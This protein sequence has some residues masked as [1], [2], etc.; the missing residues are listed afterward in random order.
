MPTKTPV[1]I[2][3]NRDILS[4]WVKHE[5]RHNNISNQVFAQRLS[6]N[7]NQVSYS[8]ISKWRNN[9]VA[10]IEEGSLRAIASYRGISEEDCELWLTGVNTELNQ[11]FIRKQTAKSKRP[12][13]T[14]LQ[15]AAQALGDSN[16]ADAAWI[17]SQG[18]LHRKDFG[19]IFRRMLGITVLASSTETPS[20]APPQA[21]SQTPYQILIDKV[22]NPL[23]RALF[24]S[25]LKK[26]GIREEVRRGELLE[27]ELPDPQEIP[28]VVEAIRATLD[29]DS[30]TL[31]RVTRALES[32]GY[33][34][35]IK[36]ETA[37][38]PTPEPED[39]AKEYRVAL[40]RVIQRGLQD[41]FLK[42]L[43]RGGVIDAQRRTAIMG[44]DL[45]TLGEIPAV[46]SA[47]RK[48]FSDESYTTLRLRTMLGVIQKNKQSKAK[49]EP[50]PA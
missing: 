25:I 33:K 41:T 17:L 32:S 12:K 7:G 42:F 6:R 3:I 15:L 13:D 21:P 10:S 2:A 9:D 48:A 28:A 5:L 46:A 16:T 29:D 18:L 30:Y 49:R 47:M 45:P 14:R 8:S 22:R 37:P 26:Q 20:Q 44:G 1:Y 38:A 35:P 19:N 27:A 40:Q 39:K 34:T 31:E 50:V 24:L 36:I 11:P 4:N 43:E 23:K